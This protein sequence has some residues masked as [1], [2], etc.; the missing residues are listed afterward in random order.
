MPKS[1]GDTG[2]SDMD[3]PGIDNNL[4]NV[5]PAKNPISRDGNAGDTGE[6]DAMPRESLDYGSNRATPSDALLLLG[7]GQPYANRNK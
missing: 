4:A 2:E 6:P 5:R 3:A 1:Y 7:A